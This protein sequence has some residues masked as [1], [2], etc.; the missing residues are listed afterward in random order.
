MRQ[1]S[2][3]P[4]GV[5]TW[6]T[7]VTRYIFFFFLVVYIVLK[8]LPSRER[9]CCVLTQKNRK[10]ETSVCVFPSHWLKSIVVGSVAATSLLF[11]FPTCSI[12][13]CCCY[14]CLWVCCHFF[15]LLWSCLFF[16]FPISIVILHLPLLEPALEIFFLFWI[17]FFLLCRY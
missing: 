7:N 6:Y 13:F 5:Q 4:A 15:F 2:L 11:L 14:S 17:I 8:S 3:L 9:V 10:T 12:L 16:F 1:I